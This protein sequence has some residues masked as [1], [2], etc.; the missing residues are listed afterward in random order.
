MASLWTLR[1][2]YLTIT[3]ERSR[4]TKQAPGILSLLLSVRTCREA[5]CCP[6]TSGL[7]SSKL[8]AFGFRP[9][10]EMSTAC[11][12]YFANANPTR[13]RTKRLI[14]GVGRPRLGL[15]SLRTV[16]I[17]V[18]PLGE[19]CAIAKAIG[20]QMASIRKAESALANELL[21]ATHLR[22]SILHQAFTGNLLPQDPS[23]EHASKL[24]E[25]IA[26]ERKAR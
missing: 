23:D 2:T 10:A 16:A 25:R 12:H 5:A 1:H 17:P 14:H 22:Q 15:S 3:S 19:Q 6:I 7:L 13:H 24:L 18:A 20:N 9:S 21:R 4:S 26:R 11:I 8:T